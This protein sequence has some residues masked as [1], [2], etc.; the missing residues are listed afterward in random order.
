MRYPVKIELTNKSKSK[1]S[2]FFNIM[3]I[4]I[5]IF[6]SIYSNSNSNKDK[7]YLNVKAK[8]K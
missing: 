2:N 3:K 4:V 8:Y 1:F 7:N 5:L 6:D